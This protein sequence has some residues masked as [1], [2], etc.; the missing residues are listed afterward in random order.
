MYP[1][2]IIRRVRKS[3]TWK[4]RW[5]EKELLAKPTY[6]APSRA[7]IQI[8]PIIDPAKTK[9][10]A[11]IMKGLLTMLTLMLLSDNHKGTASSLYYD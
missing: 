10:T 1:T 3:S 7:I 2:P 11:D 8:D 5:R 4:V 6:S 9:M